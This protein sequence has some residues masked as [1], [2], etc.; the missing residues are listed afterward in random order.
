VQ[1]IRGVMGACYVNESIKKKK[2]I[3]PQFGDIWR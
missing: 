2:I 1:Y 3:S